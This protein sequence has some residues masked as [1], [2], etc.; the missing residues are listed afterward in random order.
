[1]PRADAKTPLINPI[2][3]AGSSYGASDEFVRA[4][5]Q[6]LVA[7]L[8]ESDAELRVA[9][10]PD[11]AAKLIKAGFRVRVKKGAGGASFSDAAYGA[12]GAALGDGA[13]KTVAGAD[14]VLKINT[15]ALA[16][17]DLLPA[18]QGCVAVSYV[19]PSANGALVAALAARRVT[20][21]C[22]ACIPR[23][24][25][26]QKM[27]V[28]SSMAGIAG[29]RAVVEAA[30]LFGRFFCGQIT[31][32]ANMPPAKVLVIGAGVAGLTAVGTAK[33]LGAVV[34]AFDTREVCR[35]QVCILTYETTSDFSSVFY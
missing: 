17:V 25:R 23:I 3:G 2:A 11:N 13:K 22:W 26:A 28:L 31:A 9:L 12:V 27:D 10:A 30:H 20:A 4:G 8:A 35:E 16:E 33:S 24:S 15:L 32:A 19:N 7:V 29:Y 34:R 5:R 1:M 6:P 14:V 21:L 18:G